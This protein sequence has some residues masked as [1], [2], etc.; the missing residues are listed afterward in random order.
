MYSFGAGA[1]E[2]ILCGFQGNQTLGLL[3]RPELML[4]L[5][6]ILCSF[7]P[8]KFYFIE[9]SPDIQSSPLSYNNN[10]FLCLV[11]ESTSLW[12]DFPCCSE[13]ISLTLGLQ[14]CPG[15]LT[16]IGLRQSQTLFWPLLI[17]DCKFPLFAFCYSKVT[18]G[19]QK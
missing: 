14:V 2:H 4:I 12:C 16:L 5:H 10:L 17:C 9:I 6:T 7:E 18:F 13:S 1:S 15:G 3:C 11:T 19:T 8:I